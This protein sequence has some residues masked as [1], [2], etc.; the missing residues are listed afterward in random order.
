MST[1]STGSVTSEIRKGICRITFT[2]PAHNSLPGNLLA[3]LTREITAAGQSTDCEVIILQS[4]GD[5]T[6]CA[7]ASFDELIAIEDEGT[8]KQFF[9]GFANVINACRTCPKLIIGRIQGKAVG[10]G[11]GL[12][13]ATD[14]CFAT[15]YA[16]IKL[17]EL[18]VGIGPFVVGPAVE[19]KMGLAAFSQLAINA[20]A[21]QNA[22][23]AKDN[24]LYTEVFDDIAEMDDEIERLC[25]D[26]L[27]S[28]PAAR[29]SLKE[30]FWTGTEHWNILLETRAVKSGQLVLSPFSKSAI[31]KFKNKS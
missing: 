27:D 23:W 22:Y 6:F 28:N 21:W 29:S 30:I 16:A 3:D 24:G 18:A 19:R 1:S 2:H 10:G 20:R 31:S 5:R 14:Y 13:S 26:L 8:G 15:K 11:V 12:A 9:M 17:S 7:G 4:G 25:Q